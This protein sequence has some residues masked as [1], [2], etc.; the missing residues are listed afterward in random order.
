MRSTDGRTRVLW[1]V[2]GLGPGGMERLLVNHA[3]FG[4]RDRFA[5]QAAYLV[6]RPNSVVGELEDLG[7][8]CTRLGGGRDIDPRWLSRLRALVV[9][10]AIDVVHVHS[11]MPAAMARPVLRALRRRPSIVYTEHNTWDC[12]GRTTRVA[13]LL[14]YALDDAQFAVSTTAA[15][16]PPSHLAARVE[17]LTHGIDLDAVR[18]MGR[19]T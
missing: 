5:Y 16:S 2:K 18:Q 15:A 4:D 17:V 14:T 6:D 13:N 3:R 11:P 10:E 8:P 7:V 19:G 1:L 12:Y 9:A